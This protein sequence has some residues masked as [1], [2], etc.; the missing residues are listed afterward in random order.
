MASEGKSM[1]T[2]KATVENIG[3]KYF[4]KIKVEDNVHRHDRETNK[5]KEATNHQSQRNKAEVKC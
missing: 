4:I 3:D 5:Y 1:E 2:I